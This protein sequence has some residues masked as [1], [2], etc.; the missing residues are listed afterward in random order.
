MKTYVTMTW[1]VF[2]SIIGAAAAGCAHGEG[3]RSSTTTTTS[4]S[5]QNESRGNFENEAAIGSVN[6]ARCNREYG[7]GN[8]GPGQSFA[9][10]DACRAQIDHDSRAELSPARCSNGIDDSALASCLSDIR[11]ESCGTPLDAVERV[12]TCRSGNVC[13]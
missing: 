6:E 12:S 4:A 2:G 11:S 5:L 3:D 7:C 13:K 10:F 9:T 8:V 1:L